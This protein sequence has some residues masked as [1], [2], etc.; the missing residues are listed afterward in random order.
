MEH[1]VRG[2]R[3]KVE[4]QRC[5]VKGKRDT[6]RVRVR[7]YTQTPHVKRVFLFNSAI[8]GSVLIGPPNKHVTRQ[9]TR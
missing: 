4:E 7:T 5:G 9:K 3:S 2:E 1:W 6:E 8:S